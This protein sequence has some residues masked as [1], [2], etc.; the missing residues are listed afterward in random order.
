MKPVAQ[1]RTKQW[2]LLT[3]KAQCPIQEMTKG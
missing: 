1:R 3:I 2:I